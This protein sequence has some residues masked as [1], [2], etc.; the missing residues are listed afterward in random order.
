MEKKQVSDETRQK[1][2]VAL[3]GN[4]N[5]K[6]K[7]LG[8]KNAYRKVRGKDNGMYKHGQSANNY[9]LRKE[10]EAGRERPTRCEVCYGVGRVDFDH[11]HELGNFRGWLCRRCN[12]V[13]G[14][15][16]DQQNL[17]RNLALYL[18]VSKDTTRPKLILNGLL[19]S[20]NSNP[21]AEPTD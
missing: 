14:M 16:K 11:S 4:K 21:E 19:S 3:L 17:L 9:L 8:N 20:D 7:N 13:L 1:L 12:L 18:D 2:R 10:Q 15:V 6:G 5:G